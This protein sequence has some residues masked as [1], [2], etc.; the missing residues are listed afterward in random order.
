MKKLILATV[1]A[2]ATTTAF[3]GGMSEPVMEAPVV[4]ST[5]DEA[6]GSVSSLLIPL[7]LI[8]IVA[9]ATK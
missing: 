5:M 6:A 1:F 3:A 9:L 2:A 7:A 4:A 8:A